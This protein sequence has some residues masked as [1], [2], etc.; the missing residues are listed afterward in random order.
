MCKTNKQACKSI[1]IRRPVLHF[2]N[3]I[4]S[5]IQTEINFGTFI[6]EVIKVAHYKI[7]QSISYQL[8]IMNYCYCVEFELLINLLYE[9]LYS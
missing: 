3:V 9:Y 5:V 4:N 7:M 8:I 1:F 6:N 2:L